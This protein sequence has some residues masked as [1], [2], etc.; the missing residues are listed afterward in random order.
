VAGLPIDQALLIAIQIADALVAAHG[1][2]HRPSRSEARQRHADEIGEGGQSSPRAK[3]LD[4]GLEDG[5]QARILVTLN[6]ASG[7][8]QQSQR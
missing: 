3:L 2:R 1:R 7:L 4:F 5:E 6:W 8:A